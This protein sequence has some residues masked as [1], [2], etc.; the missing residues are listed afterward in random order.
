MEDNEDAQ[1][2]YQNL[3]QG[4]QRWKGREKRRGGKKE[5]TTMDNTFRTKDEAHGSTNP[6]G[7]I[8]LSGVLPRP[9]FSLSVSPPPVRIIFRYKLHI[10]L[11]LLPL[12][13]RR[14]RPSSP[15]GGSVKLPNS[16]LTYRV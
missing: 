15:S 5:T 8:S 10:C 12:P 9:V 4:K 16:K 14:R 3:K 6:H 13:Y 1:I 7:P 2:H 11:Q